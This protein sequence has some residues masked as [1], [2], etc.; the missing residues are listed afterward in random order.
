VASPYDAAFT[1]PDPY[2]EST[3]PVGT[4][5]SWTALP[6]P[7]GGAFANYAR[8]ELGF[9]TE[10]TYALLDSDVNRQWEWGSGHGG[11]SRLQASI[12]DDIRQQLASNPS[13]RLLIA[14]GYS[15]L[16]TPYG[17]SRYVVDH[18]PASL[19]GRR[20]ALNVYRGG[21]MFYTRPDQRAAFTADAKAFYAASGPSPAD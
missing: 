19:A 8:N 2:P 17:V 18:L 13:F 3:I 7:Y 14:H 6:A 4:T 9:K 16:V 5:P 10:M 1:T 11:G 15:D 12:T 20:V 21:H